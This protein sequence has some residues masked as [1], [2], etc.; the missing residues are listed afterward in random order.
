MSEAVE[1]GRQHRAAPTWVRIG[2]VGLF[3]LFYAYAVWN[4]I[5]EIISVSQM[6]LSG[7]GWALLIFA[8]VF[9]LIIF[10][11]AGSLGWKRPVS[12]LA[13]ALLAGLGV[14]AVFWL[15]M[16]AYLATNLQVFLQ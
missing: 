3:G 15:N 13:V 12:E 5:A 11:A 4:T 2:I 9:P 8:A 14:V 10:T 7:T 6:G 16:V 1:T